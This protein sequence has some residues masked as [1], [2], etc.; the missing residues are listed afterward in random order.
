VRDRSAGAWANSGCFWSRGWSSHWRSQGGIE[1]LVPPGQHI[2]AALGRLP[3]APPKPGLWACPR[4]GGSIQSCGH[5]GGRRA[6]ALCP[7]PRV[8]DAREDPGGAPPPPRH[9][10]D[11][12]CWRWPPQGHARERRESSG[13]QRIAHKSTHRPQPRGGSNVAPGS[14]RTPACAEAACFKHQKPASGCQ[15]GAREGAPRKNAA[16]C[17]GPRT[18]QGG[19]RAFMHH[20]SMMG[21]QPPAR[22]GG[23][24]GAAA[25]ACW[26]HMQA[27]SHLPAGFW[28]AAA[29]A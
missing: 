3:R 7:V 5:A 18:W 11:T 4:D 17:L 27:R 19:G 20:T 21:L 28:W 2:A 6:V 14:R 26:E 22:G 10:R 8:N 24:G 25:A 9:A 13:R 12:V 23:G 29:A 1:L 15:T 16:G